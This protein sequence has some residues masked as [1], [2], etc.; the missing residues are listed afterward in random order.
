M[1]LISGLLFIIVAIF[2]EIAGFIFVGSRIGILPTLA[3]LMV[4]VFAGIILLRAQGRGL[5]QRIIRELENGRTPDRA[6]IEGL[7]M[8][9]A[10]ILLIIPGFVSDILGL[11]LF[12]PPLRMC[13][14]H[15][16]AKYVTS[17]V[18]YYPRNKARSSKFEGDI[19]D[20]EEEDYQ[21]Q[22]DEKSPWRRV[23]QELDNEKK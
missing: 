5:L 18:K 22:T 4:A 13:L 9:I 15:V 1:V 6:V 17:T 21:E 16:M 23:G 14:W 8:V 10:S 12:L 19:V 7:M 2:I 20:L 3:L 11:A